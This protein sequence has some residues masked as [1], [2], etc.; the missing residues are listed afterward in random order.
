MSD[1]TKKFHTVSISFS[2]KHDA[3]LLEKLDVIR[4]TYR[5]GV[6]AFIRK[7]LYRALKLKEGGKNGD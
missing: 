7:A 3:E 4:D 2:K 5:G 1:D 6:S